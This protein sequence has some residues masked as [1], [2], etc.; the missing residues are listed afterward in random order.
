MAGKRVEISKVLNVEDDACMIVEFQNERKM[1]MVGFQAWVEDK[2]VPLPDPQTLVN[3]VTEVWWPKNL[4][5]GGKVKSAADF[6]R[7]KTSNDPSNWSTHP[8]KV[9]SVGAL[10]DMNAQAR[11]VEVKGVLKTTRSNRKDHCK[12]RAFSDTSS[13]SDYCD[14]TDGT[15]DGENVPPKK[16]SKGY[17]KGSNKPKSSGAPKKKKKS[18]SAMSR[19]THSQLMLRSV[20]GSEADGMSNSSMINHQF[21]WR[22]MSD[23]DDEEPLQNRSRDSLITKILILREELKQARQ[24]L[25]Q[26]RSLR[27]TFKDIEKAA[28]QASKLKRVL[29]SLVKDQGKAATEE[30]PLRFYDEDE[31]GESGSV[32]AENQDVLEEHAVSHE[33]DSIMDVMADI[34]HQP[35]TGGVQQASCVTPAA[36][37]I[38]QSSSRQQI[39]AAPKT[40][41][42]TKSAYS[43]SSKSLQPTIDKSNMVSFGFVN[44]KERLIKRKCLE[45]AYI[46]SGGV[47][48][49]FTTKVM[50]AV[51]TSF[52]LSNCSLSGTM[53]KANLNRKD[54]RVCKAEIKEKLP[55]SLSKNIFD[56]IYEKMNISQENKKEKSAVRAAFRQ[57]LYNAGRGKNQQASSA[58]DLQ[59]VP[60]GQA[61]QNDEDKVD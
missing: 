35:P 23:S 13:D 54:G 44:G 2:E 9:I 33:N 16:G 28:H 5:V 57:K 52:E 40:S 47:A 20:A 17:Q 21:D 15:S 8:V 50:E 58:E 59:G 61:P 14:N 46:T 11:L 34:V 56:Y 10:K 60:A 25:A 32:A 41:T 43:T 19:A 26:E 42:S 51:L 31:Q 55:E 24:D 3:C 18:S 1:I 29:R 12:K 30:D 27:A 38:Q 53:S 39:T 4:G 22:Q 7:L 48:T 36:Q 45:A 6:C 37:N 49:T